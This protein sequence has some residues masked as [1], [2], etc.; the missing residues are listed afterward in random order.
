MGLSRDMALENVPE[1]VPRFSAA[2]TSGLLLATLLGASPAILAVLLPDFLVRAMDRRERSYVAALGRL[3]VGRWLPGAVRRRRTMWAPKRFASRLGA[4]M[5]AVAIAAWVAGVWA[6]VGIVVAS[7]MALFCGLEAALGFC[8]A[9]RAYSLM[10]RLGWVRSC[11][12]GRCDLPG[13]PSSGSRP[14]PQS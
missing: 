13:E 6:P 3:T 9:C 14:V 10:G 7:V 1:W 12:D 11:P 2:V 8:V 4:V 5:I